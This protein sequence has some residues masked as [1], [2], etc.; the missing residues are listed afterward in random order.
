MWQT[1]EDT[2]DHSITPVG[3]Q[4]TEPK[5]N[6]TCDLRAFNL[7]TL[8]ST[9]EYVNISLAVIAFAVISQVG[10]NLLIWNSTLPIIISEFSVRF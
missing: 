1:N 7:Q 4:Q 3:G 6:Q 8:Q 2:R 10:V 9:T 5:P